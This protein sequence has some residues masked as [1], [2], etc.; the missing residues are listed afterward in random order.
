MASGRV[1]Y[2]SAGTDQPKAAAKDTPKPPHPRWTRPRDQRTFADI[3]AGVGIMN[4]PPAIPKAS[5]VPSNVTVISAP[6]P[7]ASAINLEAERQQRFEQLDRRATAAAAKH[8]TG[9]IG[10]FGQSPVRI[11]RTD[12]PPGRYW[13]YDF[14]TTFPHVE[15]FAPRA[16]RDGPPR[17]APTMAMS[18]PGA[19]WTAREPNREDFPQ[20]APYQFTAW[21]VHLGQ[22][23]S[24]LNPKA[25]GSIAAQEQAAAAKAWDER[26]DAH[27]EPWHS[28][29]QV[30]SPPPER[31]K[32]EDQGWYGSSRS[33]QA[34]SDSW[35]SGH[36]WRG[37]W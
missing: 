19:G 34:W 26:R 16:R 33:S 5:I 11:A 28:H 37:N 20:V 14:V 4:A 32:A 31:P 25:R 27:R 8:G 7:H 35:W 36:S 15:W 21:L 13:E 23:T 12:G 30:T 17:P 18:S 29:A 24:V 3:D 22:A 6:P 10:L 2:Q 9:H 1:V